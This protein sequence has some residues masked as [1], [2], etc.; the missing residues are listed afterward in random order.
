DAKGV[1]PIRP[2][3]D[4]IAGLT[5]KKELPAELARLHSKD[6]RALFSF[7]IR[8]DAKNV[9]DQIASVHQGGLTL[10]D[11]DYY[12]KNDPHMSDIRAKYEEYIRTMFDLLAKAEGKTESDAA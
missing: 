9:K 1:G 4:R 7:G 5:S 8:P 12:L 10:P 2:M 6:V 11:R 3:L